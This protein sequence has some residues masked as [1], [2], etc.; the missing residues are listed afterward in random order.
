MAKP[1]WERLKAGN[2][3]VY[4]QVNRNHQPIQFDSNTGT[5]RVYTS[6]NTNSHNFNTYITPEQFKTNTVNDS[7]PVQLKE[8]QITAK[9]TY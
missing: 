4:T 3:Y 8:I 9:K 2:K 1:I 5:F 6:P 7:N